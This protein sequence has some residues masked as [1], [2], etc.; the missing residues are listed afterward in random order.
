M[1]STPRA[2][3]W[4]LLPLL[5]FLALFLGSGLYHSHIGTDFAF[6]QLKAP[7]A[8]LVALLVALCLGRESLNRKLDTFIAGIGDSTIILMCLVFLLAGAFAAVTKAIG[9]VDAT[10]SLGLSLLPEQLILPGLFIVAAF[11]ATAM[12]TSMGTIG[13]LA[14]VAA[15]FAQATGLDMPLT[16]GAVIGGAM[17]GDNLSIISDTTIAATRSQNVGMRDKFMLNLRIALPAAIATLLLLAWLG[18]GAQSEPRESANVWLVLPY[19]AVLALAISGLNVI[20]VLLA[21]IV[22]SGISGLLLAPD[23]GV[24]KFGNDIYAGF[25]GMLE[26]MLL[27]MLIGGLSALMKTQGGLA[28]LSQGIAKLTTLLAIGQRRAGEFAIAAVVSLANL[29]VANNTVAIILSGEVAK[30]IA[31]KDNVDPKRSASL[32]DIFSCVVQG[33]IPWG[34]QI[35]LAGSLAGVSPLAL[36]SSVYYCWLLAA[37]AVVSIILGRPRG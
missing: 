28:W 22:L 29:F 37:V 13:A 20:L 34:A 14:P 32:L 26:I 16:M 8:A 5:V 31:Q 12:G 2:S 19:V 23:Y 18:T 35:L 7:V 33:V 24:L 15:G 11:L 36:V 1:N 6:Y 9:G 3:A 10:V 4:A 17:F 27:S 21:G 30:N 25:A